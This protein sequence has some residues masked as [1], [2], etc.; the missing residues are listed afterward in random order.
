LIDH[1]LATRNPKAAL[2]AAQSA[3][4]QLPDH[5]ELLGRQGQAQL[6]AGQGQ[7]AVSTYNRMIQL[8]A[9]S[10]LGH[11]GLAEAQM[12]A[13]DLASAG[14]SVKRA[15]EVAPA[16]LPAQRLAITIAMRQKQPAQALVLAR[17]MQQ[18]RPGHAEGYL[19]EG[20]IEAADKHWDNAVAVLR[21]AL[22]KTEPAH[23][24]ERL[25]SALRAAGKGAEADALAASWT[26][27]HPGDALFQFYLGDLALARKDLAAA[28]TRY[29]AVLQ[30]NP[31]HALALNNIAWLMLQQKR[32]GALAYAERAFHSSPDR[33]AV[34][35]T[36]ALAYAAENQAPKAVELQQR[37]LEMQPEN[38]FLRLNLA[39]FL[40]QAGDKR[41][42]KTELERLAR[43]EDKFPKQ[44]EV[45]ELLKGLG[46]R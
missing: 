33:P 21:K 46:G 40:T 41:R 18:Q 12:A 44:A 31:E 23:A 26:R 28:E 2:A 35:D 16:S 7:Q 3:L 14:R 24:V 10:P 4:A 5:F 30:I 1:H 27:E 11:L 43:L 42:A 32:A 22:T 38:P 25:H 9:K 20:E 34:I 37:A 6:A 36:L 29:Q 15:L 17:A 39:R 13:G 8:Q 19:I 45:A